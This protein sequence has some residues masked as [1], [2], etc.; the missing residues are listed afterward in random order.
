MEEGILSPE[1]TPSQGETTPTE[2]TP[3]EDDSIEAKVDEEK[4][5]QKKGCNTAEV[6]GVLAHELGHWKLSHNI[7]NIV[8]SEVRPGV[9]LSW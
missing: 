9:M 3:I 2:D 7:K 5:K 1:A 4:E 6:L 8:I